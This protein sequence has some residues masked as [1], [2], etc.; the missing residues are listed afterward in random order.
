[1]QV[2]YTIAQGWYKTCCP[3][4]MLYSV[5]DPGLMI[6]VGSSAC[7]VC[8]YHKELTNTLSGGFVECSHPDIKGED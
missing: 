3:A 5:G 6:S 2:N 7:R 4:G 8:S 1:M